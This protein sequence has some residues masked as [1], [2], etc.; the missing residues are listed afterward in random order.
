MKKTYFVI[1]M[2]LLCGFCYAQI[3]T[4]EPPK[5]SPSPQK[6]VEVPTSYDVTEAN[7]IKNVNL[8]KGQTLVVKPL[9]TK[10]LPGVKYSDR[11]LGYKGFKTMKFNVKKHPKDKYIYGT[12]D[13]AYGKNTLAS[14][15]ENKIF[16]VED[17]ESL[18]GTYEIRKIGYTRNKIDTCV[19]ILSEKDNPENKCKFIYA[20]GYGGITDEDFPFVVMSHYE[21]LKEKCI[22]KQFRFD[23]QCLS[24]FDA[25]TSKFI[26]NPEIYTWTCIDVVMSPDKGDL[27]MLLES[28]SDSLRTY[29][30]TTDVYSESGR[31]I[32]ENLVKW[33]YAGYERIVSKKYA[34][35]KEKWDSYVEKYGLESM[36]AVLKHVII[37]GMPYDALKMSWGYPKKTNSASY[38]DQLVYPNGQCV[39]I[40]DGI[41]TAWN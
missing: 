20:Y 18:N 16:I 29:I 24:Q 26:K 13:N 17:V 38:G 36:E 37:I 1:L 32:I 41:V 10:K 7:M 2:L 27:T 3:S 40:K 25:R 11:D 21:Y 39:Y 8:F 22:G 6:A 5:V 23:N 34:F 4:I 12:P 30:K 19:F 14:V 9:R 31:P 15:L 28:D 33:G 35:S